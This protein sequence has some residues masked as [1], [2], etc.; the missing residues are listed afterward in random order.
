MQKRPFLHPHLNQ[1]VVPDVG[2]FLRSE[3]EHVLLKGKVY[4]K[5]L[6]L[7]DGTRTESELVQQLA[8][9]APAAHV[10]YA[11]GRLRRQ[12]VLGDFPTD[13]PPAESAYWQL[14]NVDAG[15]VSETLRE[16]AV[17]IHPLFDFDI[18]PFTTLLKQQHISIAPAST[19]NVVFTNGYLHPELEKINQTALEDKQPW[20]L[21]RPV[22][23]SVWIGPLFV[24]QQTGCWACLANRLR[25][26]R[27]VEAYLEMQSGTLPA[28]TAV[29]A[30]PSTQ[31]LA[32]SIAA[33]EVANW[34]AQG[35]C[36]LVGHIL[37]I[38]TQS[39]QQRQHTLTRRPQCPG[40]GNAHAVKEQ[41]K[42]PFTLQPQPKQFTTDGGHRTQTPTATIEQ[43]EAQ[44]SPISGIISRLSATSDSAL[45]PAYAAD[46][47]TGWMHD[48]LY[49]LRESLRSRTGG[50]GKTDAQARASAIGESIERYAGV[51]QGNEARL[52]ARLEELPGAIHPNASM[53]FSERQFDTRD[54]WNGR[55]SSFNHVPTR[56]DPTVPIEWT[57]SW[58]L[59]D[60]TPRYL[61]TAYCFYGYNLT[62]GIH[63]VRPD[64]NGCA[65]GNTKE[66]AILQGFL[67]LVERD[68]VALWW[69]NRVK[70][71]FVNL[72]SFHDPYITQLQQHYHEQQRALWVLDLTSDLGIP[73]FA[74]LSRRLGG[75]EEQIMMGFGTHLDAHI[76]V[77]RALTE[78][79]QLLPAV[80]LGM[81]KA[82][83]SL[84]QEVAHW[85]KT[86]TI[87]E[88]DYLVGDETLTAVP[89]S[90]Y[91]TL[92]S[93]DLYTDIQT[94]ATLIQQHDM[95]ML[96]LDQ[97]R[98]DTPLHVVKVFVPGLRHFW[99][100]FAPG[101]LYDI[102]VELGWLPH[103]L[104]ESQLNPQPM[105]L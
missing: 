7:L 29:S 89:A 20:L 46:H 68:G 59:I 85:W 44:I 102:P 35:T 81:I 49:F 10:F 16:T 4:E 74:A 1:N 34:L 51:F 17:S 64:S 23:V 71:P 43:L 26:H 61:P 79:N 76:G 25:G 98:P 92:S 91:P 32:L 78:L 48:Q 28:T 24:P 58:S 47:N 67:E 18:T 70:R 62:H 60:D 75:A 14:A 54:E 66:E 19:L 101:R 77:L 40:C 37:S 12:E 13:L 86:A 21:V 99:A 65:A 30:L 57:P 3:H 90:S 103:P 42:R 63:Y 84:D 100:R 6:P 8:E 39:W 41:Q 55:Y 105:F 73:T 94:C 69:Y 2:V 52:T 50:K 9:V 22:G 56:F 97:T 38:N 93:D 11:L 87:A 88:H 31:Q 5:L 83:T 15:K 95:E 45:T 82:E 96:L 72:D 80:Q 53:L 27:K 33:T 36:P 104:S